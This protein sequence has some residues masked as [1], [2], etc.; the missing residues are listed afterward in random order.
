M[1][2]WVTARVPCAHPH[3]I[4]GGKLMSISADGEIE[5]DMRRAVSVVG[6]HESTL[7]GADQGTWGS[8]GSAAIQP[9]FFKGTTYSARMI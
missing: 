9:S 5:W 4:E 8:Y 1:I 2:D 6:S 7:Q 3:V